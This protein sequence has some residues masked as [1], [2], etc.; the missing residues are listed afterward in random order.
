MKAN[1]EATVVNGQEIMSVTVR[2]E[3]PKEEAAAKSSGA[4]KKWHRGWHPAVGR[5]EKPK[6]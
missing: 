5:S 4:L 1:R 2:E 3:V 6:E